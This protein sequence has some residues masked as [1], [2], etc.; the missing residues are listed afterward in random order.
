MPLFASKPSKATPSVGDTQ[1][2][3]ALQRGVRL[4]RGR[5]WGTHAGGGPACPL[6]LNTPGAP[7]LAGMAGPGAGWCAGG[8]A[9]AGW[10]TAWGVHRDKV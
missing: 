8:A 7:V 2:L 3:H 5:V 9:K 4:G 10:Y 1:E 6:K